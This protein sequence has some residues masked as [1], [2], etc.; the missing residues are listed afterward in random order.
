[1]A[2]TEKQWNDG[3]Y[4]ARALGKQQAESDYEEFDFAQFAEAVE[5]SQSRAEDVRASMKNAEMHKQLAGR[6]RADVKL[7]FQ[8]EKALAWHTAYADAG[9]ELIEK[10]LQGDIG[11]RLGDEDDD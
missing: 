9:E 2:L 11:Y 10:E 3:I 8:R 5:K 4:G 7:E 6:L 1:M